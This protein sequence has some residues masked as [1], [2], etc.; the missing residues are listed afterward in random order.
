MHKSWKGAGLCWDGSSKA[1]VSLGLITEEQDSNIGRLRQT[2]IKHSYNHNWNI[3]FT[4][5]DLLGRMWRIK[6]VLK[7]VI[8]SVL[9]TSL[10][11][12][13]WFAHSSKENSEEIWSL[14]LQSKS[15]E[16][17]PT[18]EVQWLKDVKVGVKD[19]EEWDKTTKQ[20]TVWPGIHYLQ[21]W[22]AQSKS[23]LSSDNWIGMKQKMCKLRQRK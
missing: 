20:V 3:A 22:Q 17:A 14:N 6:S 13:N 23:G 12:R 16:A 15:R 4:P 10:E 11:W 21:G 2:S 8:G 9:S 1:H 18:N 7:K 19:R 5:R